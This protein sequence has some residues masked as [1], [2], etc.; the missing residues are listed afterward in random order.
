MME[1]LDAVCD[2]L[3]DE[4]D[5]LVG[6]VKDVKE[7]ER[8]LWHR[9]LPLNAC[10]FKLIPLFNLFMSSPKDELHQWIVVCSCMYLSVHGIYTEYILVHT[11]ILKLF[12]R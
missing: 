5:K 6:R 9:L 10:L 7:V 12:H 2:Q 4:D 1:Q 11:C 8:R 3:L